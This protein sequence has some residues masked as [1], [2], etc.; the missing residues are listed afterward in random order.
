MPTVSLNDEKKNW[1]EKHKLLRPANLQRYLSLDAKEWREKNGMSIPI[2][3]W[4]PS[5]KRQSWHGEVATQTINLK[6]LWNLSL[7]RYNIQVKCCFNPKTTFQSFQA[8][9]SFQFSSDE[10]LKIYLFWWQ[11]YGGKWIPSLIVN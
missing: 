4:T 10:D 2:E 11:Q 9:F 6:A 3:N 5:W 8:F 7:R 1:I